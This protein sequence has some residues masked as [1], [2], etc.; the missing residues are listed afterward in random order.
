MPKGPEEFPLD[1]LSA[2]QFEVLTFLLARDEFPAVV[3][4]RRKDH[5]LD[6]R[7]P[8]PSGATL[9]GWQS[10]RFLDRIYWDQC[11]ESVSRALAF[12]RPLRIT[13]VFPKVLSAKEQDDFRIELTEKFP[14]VRLEWWD[15]SELQP[16][17]RDTAGGRRAADWLF[18]N[19]EAD[20]A[21]LQRVLAVS[22]ELSDAAHAAARVAEVQKFMSQ[23]PHFRYTTI[24]SE[25]D[26]PDTPRAE[27]TIA[28]IEADFGGMHVRFDASERYPGSAIDFGLRGTLSF[29]QDAEGRRAHEAVM[30]VIAEGGTIDISSGMSAKLDRVPVGLRGLLPEEEMTGSFQVAAEGAQQAAPPPNFPV[31]V[32]AGPAEIGM[33]L[34]YVDPVEGWDVTVGGSAGG[35]ELF[36][37]LRGDQDARERRMDWRWTL[38]EG[39][40]LEQLLA[41]EVMLAA[42]QREVVRLITPAD[43]NAVAELTVYLREGADDEVVEIQ[44]IRDFLEY[45][46]EAEAWLGTPLTP[47]A[48]PT[49]SDARVLSWLVAQIRTPEREG[50]LTRLQ[51]SLARPI[52]DIEQPFQIAAMQP[53]RAPLFGEDRYLGMQ[54]MHVPRAR[55]DGV[56]GNE[57]PGETVAVVPADAEVKVT[58]RFYAPTDAPEAMARPPSS[59]PADTTN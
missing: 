22:G 38:G 18:G 33:V 42:H 31:L 35:L 54:M 45:A 8:E 50:S 11:Q 47:P 30:R 2:D 36:L 12:W 13:F 52:A 32:R 55:F 9:R 7:L 14:R 56:A 3:H 46:A 39:N 43:G 34:G 10:K 57:Q 26:A 48:N 28:S 23:D 20:K 1:R 58:T 27:E 41:A 29:G 51:F 16:R 15:A 21:E 40:A 19:P 53:F 59:E 49:D 5:G 4:V 37:S 24:A 25:R 44:S 6:A 17:M